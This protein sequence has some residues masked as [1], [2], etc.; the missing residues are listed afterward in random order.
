VSQSSTPTAG[1]AGWQLDVAYW[2]IVLKKS[3]YRLDPIFSAPQ[4][5][6][7][8]ADVRGLVIHARLN[9]DHSKSICGGNQRQSK[10]SLAFWQICN[11][12]I[13]ATFSTESAQMRLSRHVRLRAATG[14]KPDVECT[15]RNARR[16]ALIS[17]SLKRLSFK[18]K[19]VIAPKRIDATA[20]GRQ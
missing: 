2:P 7:S 8:D 16:L 20:R 6:F 3:E 13:L 14:R 18:G 9:V 17:Q 19:H 5:R 10:M 4:V 1:A 12:F 11:D 15:S